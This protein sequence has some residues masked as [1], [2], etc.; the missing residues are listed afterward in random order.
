MSEAIVRILENKVLIIAVIT[1]FIA[2]ASKVITVLITKRRFDF[3][4][5]LSSGGMPSAHSAMV[6]SLA[7][8]VG[9]YDGWSS[10][11]FGLAAVFALV[12]MYDA[13]GVRRAAGKQAEL[14][15]QIVDHIYHHRRDRT[16]EKLKELLGHTPVEVVAG[17]ILGIGLGLL[18]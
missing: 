11:I 5:L 7:T 12:V 2:Q 8:A 13:A 10:S 16:Q 18:L 14:L 15:N 4:P 1:W 6:T 9:K 17:A 3:A